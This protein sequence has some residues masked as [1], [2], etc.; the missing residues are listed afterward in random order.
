MTWEEINRVLQQKRAIFFGRGEWMEKGLNYIAGADYV[1]DNNKYEHGQEELGLTIHSPVK[2][3]TEVPD[4]IFIIIATT[5]FKDVI[6]QLT[7]F[8]FTPGQHFC[9]SPSLKNYHAITRIA[10]H[11]QTV[12]LTCSD[13]YLQG[14]NEKGGGLYSFELQSGRMEKIID[15]LCHGLVEGDGRY[16]LVD[17][18]TGIRILDTDFKPIELFELPGKSRPHG[19]AYCPNRDLIFVSLSGRDTIG[20]YD[21]K[22][23]KLVDEI[24]L[25]GK[26]DKTA[27]AQHHVNDLFVYNNSLY[28]SMFSLS[29]N[30]KVG[31]YDGGILEYDIDSLARIGPVVTGLWLPHT[32]VVIKG[33]LMYCDSM[34]GTVVGNS[35]KRLASFNGFVRGITYDDEFFYIGQSMHRYIDRRVGTTDN[36]SLDTGIFIVEPENKVTRFFSMPHLTDINTVFIPSKSRSVG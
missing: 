29:G 32:P 15:G 34:R 16:Y 13:R 30:W 2:L 3:T 23:F 8:G 24:K 31:V 33:N 20:I 19:I 27:I 5:G 4:E 6:A 9:V 17:D 12:Y 14:D 10:E 18:I 22:D 35:G 1:V 7:D 25:S 36:I 26:W 21:G 28:I 11:E